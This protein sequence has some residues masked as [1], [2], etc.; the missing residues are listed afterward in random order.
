MCW[1]ECVLAGKEKHPVL[2]WSQSTFSKV[3][4]PVWLMGTWPWA[5][6]HNQEGAIN[7]GWPRLGQ[8]S[9]GRTDFKFETEHYTAQWRVTFPSPLQ[10]TWGMTGLENT[11]AQYRTW[12]PELSL[13]NSRLNMDEFECI[14]V[15]VW[16]HTY[17]CNLCVSLCVPVCTVLPAK[18]SDQ[19]TGYPTG[20]L[21][22]ETYGMCSDRTVFPKC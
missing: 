9:V 20:Y 11:C 3:L 16:V 5:L 15:H 22:R 2:F 8:H 12:I 17:V 13:G 21:A 10:T 18:H 7:H 19:V 4:P 6:W 1:N 14:C